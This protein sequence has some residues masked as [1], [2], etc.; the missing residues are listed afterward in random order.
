MDLKYRKR[1]QIDPESGLIVVAGRLDREE[2]SSYNLTV[3]ATDGGTD[4]GDNMKRTSTC[5]VIIDVVDVNDNEP[6]FSK[7]LYEV[8][9]SERCVFKKFTE[10]SEKLKVHDFIDFFFNFKSF[11]VKP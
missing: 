11:L 7:Q 8:S 2:Q 5:Y 9:I 10:C 6:Q 1:F 4:E 3:V